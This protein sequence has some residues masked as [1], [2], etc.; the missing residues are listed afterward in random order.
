MIIADSSHCCALF[1]TGND[2]EYSELL[3]YENMILV[4]SG[5]YEEA[6]KHLGQHED[7]IVDRL[8]VTETRGRV[9]FSFMES[10]ALV[11]N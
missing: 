4:E 1:Q 7:K 3:V 5:K 10:Y 6:L 11:L 9:Q 8:V 2:Y